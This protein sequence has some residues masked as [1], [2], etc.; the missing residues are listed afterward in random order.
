[1]SPANTD[2]FLTTRR[3]FYISLFGFQNFDRG[4]G[5]GLLIVSFGGVVET[6]LSSKDVFHL[7]WVGVG[8]MELQQNLLHSK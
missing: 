7:F 5:A 1:M 4:F 3:F 8:G 6:I 2:L